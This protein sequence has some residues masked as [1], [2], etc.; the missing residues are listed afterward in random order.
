MSTGPQTRPA[1]H[2]MANREPTLVQAAPVSPANA[3]PMPGRITDAS[4]TRTSREIAPDSPAGQAVR[5]ATPATRPMFIGTISRNDKQYKKQIAA[6][7]G[8]GVKVRDT[9]GKPL[10]A[11]LEI[12]V[13]RF[14]LEPDDLPVGGVVRVKGASGR[15]YKLTIL[16]IQDAK[17]T[18]RFALERVD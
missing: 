13:G 7:D 17:E 9:D 6:P 14:R 11:D 1:D 10:D 15:N 16:A 12:V 18:V 8:I 3:A 4:R 5:P 2:A